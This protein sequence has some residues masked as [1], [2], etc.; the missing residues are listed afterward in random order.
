ML[1]LNNIKKSKS[2][3]I[4]LTILTIISIVL[5]YVGSSVILDLNSFFDNK[6]N[7][8]NDA[9]VSLIVKDDDLYKESY[10][11]IKNNPHTEKVETEDILSFDAATFKSGENDITSQFIIGDADNERTISNIKFTEKAK[12]KE[13]NGII[14]S[15]NLKSGY[16]YKIGDEIEVKYNNINLKFKVYGFFED[17]LYSNSAD[18]MVV[19]SYV[20]H[21]DYEKL[22]AYLSD[23]YQYKIINAKTDT[24]ENSHIVRK[25]SLNK[26][27][28]EFPGKEYNISGSDSRNAKYSLNGYIVILMAMLIGFSVILEIISLIVIGFS[29]VTYITDNI[30]N[31]GVLQALGYVNNQVIN[32]SLV[33]F[34][35]IAGT[36]SI[37]GLIVAFGVTPSVSNIVSSVV[38]LKWISRI[39]LTAAVLSVILI[40][41]LVFIITYLSARKIKKITPIVALRSGIST[42]NFKKN[43]IKL[44]GYKGSINF[45]ISLKAIFHYLRQ[46]CMIVIIIFALTFVSIFSTVAYYNFVV[47]DKFIINLV[48]IEKFYVSVQSDTDTSKKI[49]D[50]IKSNDKVRKVAKLIEK[51]ILVQDE[52]TNLWICDD[53]NLLENKIIYRGRDPIHDNEV[54]LSNVVAQSMNKEIGDTMEIKV[55]GILKDFLIVGISQHITGYGRSVRMTEEGYR[56]YYP[57]FNVPAIGIYLKDNASSDEFIKMLNEKYGDNKVIVT[58]YKVFINSIVDPLK[59]PI[60]LMLI[61][62]VTITVF[63]VCLILFLLIKI[64][65]L[66]ERTHL[67]LLK[68][69]GYT[70]VQLVFQTVFSLL[71]VIIVGVLIGAVGGCLLSNSLMDLI[72]SNM[73]I[74]NCNLTINYNY[75]SLVVIGIVAIAY[76]FANLVAYR[77]RKI[78]PYELMDK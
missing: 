1:A 34:M 31:I 58:N 67:G 51:S 44:E 12:E 60:V 29:I 10:L 23:T 41:F 57:N 45:A 9:N 4:T 72:V 42:H 65:V 52:R 69:L 46:N 75:A 66:K 28:E 19:K 38:G 37:L 22:R 54:A 20:F 39:N 17:T 7:E 2:T 18:T 3:A 43:Y 50:E 21:D 15:Y 48:G 35:M 63:V 25:D 78:T 11:L 55:D 16:G 40:L 27:S 77:I 73:G 5:L 59:P 62:F 32:I 6:V 14:L 26:L 36:G 13:E 33:Q 61:V 56:R 8:L 76:I 53:Y 47:N 64:R 24:I 68:A 49:Y 70:T 74:H 30:K 71:P